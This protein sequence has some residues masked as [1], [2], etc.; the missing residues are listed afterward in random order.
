MSDT[1]NYIEK[2]K[3]PYVQSTVESTLLALRDGNWKM[4]EGAEVAQRCQKWTKQIIRTSSNG[5]FLSPHFYLPPS[6]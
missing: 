4:G 5:L 6:I 1:V 2:K 3:I